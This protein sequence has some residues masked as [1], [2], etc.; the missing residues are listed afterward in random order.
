MPD[1][2]AIVTA[3]GRGGIYFDSAANKF[4]FSENGSVWLDLAPASAG[5]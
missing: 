4:K 2:V 1:K 5:G 3:A